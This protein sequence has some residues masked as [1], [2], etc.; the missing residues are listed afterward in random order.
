MN[1]FAGQLRRSKRLNVVQINAQR[2]DG[3]GDNNNGDQYLTLGDQSHALEDKQDHID[4]QGDDFL[5]IPTLNLC[6]PLI[7]IGTIKYLMD[8]NLISTF[9]N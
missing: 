5:N 8:I 9:P 7:H 4:N 6:G 2:V 1:L 3:D